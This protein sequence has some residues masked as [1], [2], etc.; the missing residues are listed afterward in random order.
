MPTTRRIPN[1]LYAITDG[2]HA[3]LLAAC[4]ATLCGSARVL[5][6]RDKTDSHERRLAEATQLEKLCGNDE[7]PLIINA[8][9]ELARTSGASGVHPGTRDEDIE[10][11]RIRLGHDAIIGDTCRASL[12]L[13]RRAASAGA[14]YVAFRAFH[15]SSSKPG[16]TLAPVSLLAEAR[17]LGLPV[18]AIGGITPDNG[19]ALIAA[20]ANGLAVLSALFA[21]ADT[22][23]QRFAR[24]FVS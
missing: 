3:D 1:G 15:A 18:V 20:G 13:A 16:A 9:A 5:Q 12:D 17:S 11:A 14:D 10:Q 2:P 24:L 4:E 23:P 7:V 19:A 22:P 6:Y 8:D 21:E